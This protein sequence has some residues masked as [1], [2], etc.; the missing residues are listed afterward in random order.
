M[1]PYFLN[2][3]STIVF[4]NIHAHAETTTLIKLTKLFD[5]S[6]FQYMYMLIV[7]LQILY[8]MYN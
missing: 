4:N 7:H 1:P 6:Q 3:T 8:V 5:S 2:I